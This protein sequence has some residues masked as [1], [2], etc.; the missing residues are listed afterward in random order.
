MTAPGAFGLRFQGIADGRYVRDVM[1]RAPEHW[2]TLRVEQRIEDPLP[3]VPDATTDSAG[4][5]LAGGGH[6]FVDR[7]R[8][9]VTFV[10]REPVNGHRVVHPTLAALG[11]LF[12]HW[13][14][15]HALHAGGF[16]VDGGA[17]AVIGRSQAGKTSTLAWLAQAGSPILTDDLMVVDG[18][19]VFAGPRTLDLRPAS[20]RYLGR[21][22]SRVRLGRHRITVQPV[23]PEVPLRGWI[24]LSWG[25]VLEAR[26]LRPSERLGVLMEHLRIRSDGPSAG[27]LLDLAALPGFELRRPRTLEAMPQAGAKIVE[28]ATSWRAPGYCV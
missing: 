6:A 17:W 20:A 5:E 25:D 2:P 19:T 23:D 10:S 3:A 8:L 9:T 16:V 12:S 27:S 15:R 21:E 28:L 4:I 26:R 14:G 24:A 11:T 7:D 18:G 13:M 22:G 1:V